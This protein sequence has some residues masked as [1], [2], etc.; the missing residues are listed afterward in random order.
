ME[1]QQYISMYDILKKDL[2]FVILIFC[3]LISTGISWIIPTPTYPF[4]GPFIMFPFYVSIYFIY[5]FICK[6]LKIDYWI[7]K[8]TKKIKINNKIVKK[9]ISLDDKKK[10]PILYLYLFLL[11]ICLL[12]PIFDTLSAGLIVFVIISYYKDQF[13]IKL[14]SI[15]VSSLYIIFYFYTLINI[16]KISYLTY[17]IVSNNK[18]NTIIVCLLWFII[19]IYL[20]Y[21]NIPKYKNHIKLDKDI[22]M[23]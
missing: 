7:P 1:N 14:F 17:K 20:V 2:I 6:I 5:M 11:I 19:N 4:L 9:Y 12:V 3:Y 16:K 15:L 23:A 18:K 10:N 22:S 21:K 13:L 8:I